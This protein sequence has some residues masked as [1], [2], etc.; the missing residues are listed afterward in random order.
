MAPSRLS[1]A[2]A[3]LNRLVKEEKSYY[4]ESEHQQARIAKL[5]Q[6]NSEDENADFTLRQEVRKLSRM[7]FGAA[8]YIRPSVKL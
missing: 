1:I 8:T 3:S 6:G 5:E 4:K 7:S 2:T